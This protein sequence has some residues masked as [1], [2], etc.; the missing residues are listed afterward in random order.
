M[1]VETCPGFPK[2]LIHL[3]S[4]KS[5]VKYKTDIDKTAEYCHVYEKCLRHST[6]GP[7]LFLIYGLLFS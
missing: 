1:V 4:F 3:K 7:L 5:G 6:D 2:Y